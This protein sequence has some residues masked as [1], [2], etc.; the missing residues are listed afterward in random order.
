[1]VHLIWRT[2]EPGQPSPLQDG[3]GLV[4]VLVNLR[5]PVPQVLLHDP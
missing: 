5:V 4:H 3:V 2:P 1:M